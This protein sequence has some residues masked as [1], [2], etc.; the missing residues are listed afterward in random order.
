MSYVTVDITRVKIS[1]SIHI[2]EWYQVVGYQLLFS[3]VVAELQ[4]Y[5]FQPRVL[6]S[7]NN[8]GTV[9]FPTTWATIDESISVTAC[10]ENSYN[11]QVVL[12][13]KLLVYKL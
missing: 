4:L 3:T 7:L 13:T 10:L 5:S 2:D 12:S 6:S 9:V 1:N 8:L 11:L